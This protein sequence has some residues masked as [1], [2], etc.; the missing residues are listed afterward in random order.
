MQKFSLCV[1]WKEVIWIW[2]MSKL[3]LQFYLL[4]EGRWQKELLMSH[5]QMSQKCGDLR[6]ANVSDSF[7]L[8]YSG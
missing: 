8:S 5:F 1:L 7:S 3:F 6:L 2:K 4:R